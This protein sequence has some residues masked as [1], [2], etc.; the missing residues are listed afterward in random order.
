M[1]LFDGA[2]ECELKQSKLASHFN[3]MR[4]EFSNLENWTLLSGPTSQLA[5]DYYL[6]QWDQLFA[7][8]DNEP[9]P[10]WDALL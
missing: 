8:K 3:Q 10:S 6:G 2:V 1:P 4:V 9:L 5:D 7:C